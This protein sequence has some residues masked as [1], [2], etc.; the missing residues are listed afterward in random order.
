[1]SIKAIAVTEG[2][3][4]TKNFNFER[5]RT[6]YDG[7]QVG[8]VVVIERYDGKPI[9]VGIVTDRDLA[10]T[11]SLPVKNLKNLKVEDVMAKSL[12]TARANDGIFETIMENDGVRS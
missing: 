12:V 1:M 11:L 9:P 3:D 5:C 8:S 6:P 7:Q 10:L 2:R 4:H